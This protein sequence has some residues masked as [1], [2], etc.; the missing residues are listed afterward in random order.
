ML[1]V[2]CV[3]L[4][5]SDNFDPLFFDGSSFFMA[6]CCCGSLL[7][8]PVCLLSTPTRSGDGR[9]ASP[10]EFAEAW[11]RKWGGIKCGWK[12]V[13]VRVMWLP[14]WSQFSSR[15]MSAKAFS[16]GLGRGG[17]DCCTC[18]LL[19]VYVDVIKKSIA[20]VSVK[21]HTLRGGIIRE[22]GQVH[23]CDHTKIAR[24]GCCP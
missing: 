6:W 16:G 19:H 15:C 8:P 10:C 22:R 12:Q 11:R 1:S 24:T 21:V 2:P 18:C 23:L 3:P 20:C 7:Y 13:S 4:D 14:W 5:L 9:E 17:A